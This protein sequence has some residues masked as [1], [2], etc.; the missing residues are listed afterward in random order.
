MSRRVHALAI[1][2]C[3]GLAALSVGVSVASAVKRAASRVHNAPRSYSTTVT[4]SRG[5]RFGIKVTVANPP[6][7]TKVPGFNVGQTDVELDRSSVAL[8]IKNATPGRLADT[9][10]N[11][12]VYVT[13]LWRIPGGGINSDQHYRYFAWFQN[14]GEGGVTIPASGVVNLPVGNDYKWGIRSASSGQIARIRSLLRHAPTYVEVWTSSFDSFDGY[15]NAC[16]NQAVIAVF[17]SASRAIHP[18]SA[19][20]DLFYNPNP[21]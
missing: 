5:Y 11:L 16:G 19:L 8:S 17:N 18:T 7:L 15:W 3:L 9:G 2:L 20:C 14:F 4:S 21:G 6:Q 10:D 1:F 12:G 13:L